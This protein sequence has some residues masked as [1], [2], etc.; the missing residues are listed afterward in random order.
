MARDTRLFCEQITDH[1]RPV[2]DW[3]AALAG[4]CDRTSQVKVAARLG[5]S[6]ALISGTLKRSYKGDLSR[7][8]ELVRGALLSECVECP[9][10]GEITRDIC[11][12]NQSRDF[13]ATSS[14]RTRVYRA[15]RSGCPHSKLE[16]S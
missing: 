12:N 1:W 6:N 10:L 15:C 16:V 7:I 9:V 5:V 4:E 3:V 13:V 11:L 8:E 2:P 14:V